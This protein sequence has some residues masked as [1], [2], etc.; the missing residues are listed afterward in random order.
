MN[1]SL[2]NQM[3]SLTNNYFFA[4]ICSECKYYT[5]Q[6]HIQSWSQGGGGSQSRKF[7]EE[8]VTGEVAGEGR[9]HPPDLKKTT[10][11]LFTIVIQ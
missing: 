1:M 4:G 10:I 8:W 7:K 9:C 3:L 11:I 2:D 6:W 5:G